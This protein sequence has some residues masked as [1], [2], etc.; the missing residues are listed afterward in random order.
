MKKKAP[1]IE[2][3]ELMFMGRA[4][5]MED[6]R[7]DADKRSE[8]AILADLER[9]GVA[10]DSIYDLVNA[11]KGYDRGIPVLL[12]HVNKR[13]TISTRCICAQCLNVPGILRHWE[14]LV[15]CYRQCGCAAVQGALADVVYFNGKKEHGDDIA[16]MVRM[17]GKLGRN[18]MV[19]KLAQLKY[20]GLAQLLKDLDSL[21]LDASDPWIAK[22]AMKGWRS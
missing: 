8:A 21:G 6:L 4:V 11:G 20:E 18:V 9:A 12:K 1:R 14:G 17:K 3:F 19:D 5:P 2:P 15:A 16:N 7:T 22:R 10:A 13:H